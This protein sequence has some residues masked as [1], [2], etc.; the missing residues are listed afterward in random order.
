MFRGA[1]LRLRV[2]E[3]SERTILRLFLYCLVVHVRVQLSSRVTRGAC[4]VGRVLDALIGALLRF[5]LGSVEVLKG[6]TN[7]LRARLVQGACRALRRRLRLLVLTRRAEVFTI[8]R[9]CRT[10]RRVLMA[11]TGDVRVG[12]LTSTIGRMLLLRVTSLLLN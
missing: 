3:G 9:F 6:R 7:V 5:Y 4:L 1:F 2:L 10:T 11:S 12:G 8:R